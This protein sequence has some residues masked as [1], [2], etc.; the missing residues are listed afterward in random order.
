M[1][2]REVAPFVWMDHDLTAADAPTLDA[3]K[4]VLPKLSKNAVGSEDAP[5]PLSSATGG[6]AAWG[7]RENVILGTRLM[8]L[9][10]RL[11]ASS[12]D[13]QHGDP[14]PIPSMALLVDSPT[15]DD[16]KP[17]TDDQRH[18]H[19]HK[20]QRLMHEFAAMSILHA[21]CESVKTHAMHV[22]ADV[23]V[24]F[25]QNIGVVLRHEFEKQSKAARLAALRR[26]PPIDAV[27]LGRMFL[28]M[29]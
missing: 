18:M 14:T 4:L 20:A 13:K 6:K 23:G 11:Q 2:A 8:E 16:V 12:I 9:K 3:E 22:L 7:I 5:S 29:G 1:E 27:V 10:R 17:S 19:A 21:G 15:S 26:E 25:I 28:F 24:S